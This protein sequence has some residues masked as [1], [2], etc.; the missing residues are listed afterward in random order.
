MS[1]LEYLTVLVSII[2]GLGVTD[3][4][5]SLRDLIHPDRPV[6]WHWLPLAWSLA[7]ILMVVASWWGFFDLLQARVWASPVAFLLVLVTALSLYLLCAF[8][9][10]DLDGPPEADDPALVDLEAFYFSPSHRRSFFGV[11]IVFATSFLAIANIE[12]VTAEGIPAA[13]AATNAAVTISLYVVP[14]S[15]LLLT[16]R[17]WVHV[18]GAVVGLL[19]A[20][21]LLFA[22]APAL[23]N[24]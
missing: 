3:L 21:V 6:R 16:E 8:A 7:A 13:Q 4:A 1:Q 22:L 5:Q 11:A 12:R 18:L 14:Y 2:V 10:P 20:L 24:G 19:L 9:L 15:I 23:T 17:T